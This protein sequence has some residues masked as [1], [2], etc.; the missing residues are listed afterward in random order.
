MNRNIFEF[1]MEFIDQEIMNKYIFEFKYCNIYK[2]I[3]CIEKYY[4]I[5]SIM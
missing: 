4:I 3:F 2:S 5:Y 1:K